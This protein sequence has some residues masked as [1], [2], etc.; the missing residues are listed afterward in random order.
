MRKK[1]LTIDHLMNELDSTRSLCS[2]V[3]TEADNAHT[4]LRLKANFKLSVLARENLKNRFA[5]EN[6]RCFVDYFFHWFAS[7]KK[8]LFNE[9]LSSHYEISSNLLGIA[10]NGAEAME[11]LRRWDEVVGKMHTDL[12]ALGGF[13]ADCEDIPVIDFL[14]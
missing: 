11:I 7:N 4:D 6:L 9:K 5:H 8:K 10:C 2:Q 3:M 14:N 13:K 12:E 1:D